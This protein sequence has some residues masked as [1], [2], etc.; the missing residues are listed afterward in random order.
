MAAQFLTVIAQGARQAGVAAGQAAQQ[1]ARVGARV[2][3]QG[4]RAGGRVAQQGGRVAQEGARASGRAA[5]QGVRIGGRAAQQ[6]ARTGREAVERVGTTGRSLANNARNF[7]REVKQARREWKKAKKKDK[8]E[9]KR[10]MANERERLK[11]R[12]KVFLILLLV[13]NLPLAVMVVIMVAMVASKEAAGDCTD[14]AA[15]EQQ[16]A[17]SN[18][19]GI[20]SDFLEL[21]KK[22]GKEYNI[23]WNVLAAIGK[24]ESTHYTDPDSHRENWAG[25]AGPMQFLAPTWESYKV[26]GDGDGKKDRYDPDDAIP[27]AANYLV[28]GLSYHK[29]V[30]KAIFGY[31]HSWDY[32]DLILRTAKEYGGGEVSVLPASGESSEGCEGDVALPG[33]LSEVVKRII[34]FAVAQRGKRYV[35]GANGPDAWD[36]SSLTEAAYRT[37]GLE[38]GA[39][40]WDQYPKGVKVPKGKEQPGDLV[41]FNSGPGTSAERPGHVGMVIGKNRMIVARCTQCRPGVDITPYKRPDWVMVTRPLARPDFQA[42]LKKAQAAD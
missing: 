24:V 18:A 1:G 11:R 21:Y 17:A 31:N 12:I 7:T 26:D 34:T 33:N 40:T 13:I 5:Q 37:V 10:Q 38:I 16:P 42:K 23:P 14:S 6:S 22:A 27:G 30:R 15:V 28:N 41:F 4:A 25:A 3:Q 36:C 19:A 8:D 9:L 32:V 20:P 35:L 29:D 2:A 39:T